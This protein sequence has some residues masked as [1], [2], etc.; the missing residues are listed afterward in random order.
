MDL[1]RFYRW[2]LTDDQATKILDQPRAGDGVGE[3]VL[4]GVCWQLRRGK[5][6]ID[7]TPNELGVLPKMLADETLKYELNTLIESFRGK[8]LDRGDGKGL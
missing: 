4:D 8:G 5:R 3:A 1:D 6:D 2:T 7:L